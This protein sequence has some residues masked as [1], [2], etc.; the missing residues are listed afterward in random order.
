MDCRDTAQCA[1]RQIE[2]AALPVERRLDGAWLGID[3]GDDAE[4]IA[5]V[6]LARLPRDVG[7]WVTLPEIRVDPAARR[8]GDDLACAIL[9]EAI[10]HDPIEAG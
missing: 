5:L 4:P 3:V 10:D 7:R 1:H 9:I 6:K 2:R 8:L